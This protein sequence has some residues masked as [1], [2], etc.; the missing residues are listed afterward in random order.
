MRGLRTRITPIAGMDKTQQASVMNVVCTIT[1]IEGMDE[2][3]QPSVVKNDNVDLL[4]VS[5]PCWGREAT[6]VQV[7]KID[8]CVL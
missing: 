5:E 3:Q 4:F 7:S 6:S 2:A 8:V 1:V